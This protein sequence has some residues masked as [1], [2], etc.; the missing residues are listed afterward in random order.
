VTA[1]AFITH[2]GFCTCLTALSALVVWAMTRAGVIDTPGARSSHARPTPKGGGVGIVVAFLIGIGVLYAFAA[3]SRLADPY[4]RAVILAAAG[5]AIV[6]YLDDVFAWPAS[7]KLAAQ[8]LAATVAVGSGLTIDEIRLPVVGAVALGWLGP[9]GTLVW[10]VAATNAMNFIDGL[11]GL[12][13]G[14]S[15]ITC[16]F[17]AALAAA[18]GAWFVYFAALILAAGLLGFLPFNFPH[19]RIFMGDVG[20]Q[21]CGFLLAVLAIAAGRFEA[22]ELSIALVPML[23]FGVLFDVAFTLV[24]RAYAGERLTEAHRGHLYQ[25]A[26][27]S[28]LPAVYVTLVHWSFAVWGGLCCFGLTAAAPPWKPMWVLLVVPPQ[29]VWLVWVRRWARRAAIT[30]W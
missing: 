6:A 15:M 30:R 22:V 12:A 26:H 19:A 8:V 14:V 1:S 29:L 10:I 18:L 11:N 7:V 24:R 3:F 17:L 13:A 23:L 27:R 21:F 20:S 16:L 5:I 2:L 4:F 28:G 25:I 9:V